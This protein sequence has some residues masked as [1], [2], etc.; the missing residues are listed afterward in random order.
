MCVVAVS[1]RR[2]LV[3]VRVAR[4]ALN[5][6]RRVEHD[7]LDNEQN[8][9][10]RAA[11]GRRAVQDPLTSAAHVPASEKRFAL[12]STPDEPRPSKGR[13][14]EGPWK[15]PG[16][17]PPALEGGNGARTAH[18]KKFCCSTTTGLTLGA[19]MR[20]LSSAKGERLGA[21]AT[22]AV[23]RSFS[24]GAGVSTTDT[25]AGSV[26]TGASRATG[27]ASSTGVAT[28]VD[29]LAERKRQIEI[30]RYALSRL[31]R[32]LTSIGQRRWPPRSA[33]ASGA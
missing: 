7:H 15:P 17:I 21:A 13:A 25:G 29:M 16:E 2:S 8:E 31:V 33:G 20:F 22:G 9:P 4:E 27:A 26:T 3:A 28:W 6:S 30:P 12:D 19:K 23:A 5:P 11:S 1:V 32:G 10:A 14:R 24:T 18:E